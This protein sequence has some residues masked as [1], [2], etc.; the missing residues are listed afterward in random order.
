MTL[1]QLQQINVNL[2]PKDSSQ[3]TELYLNNSLK[4]GLQKLRN[5]IQCQ[6]LF[7][8][9]KTI[10]H[11]LHNLKKDQIL[12][13]AQEQMEYIRSLTATCANFRSS[14]HISERTGYKSQLSVL[15][16]GLLITYPK[17]QVQ[18]TPTLVC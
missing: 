9:I 8:L 17:G 5:R 10:H 7:P 3:I 15:I 6:S 16:L 12:H 1:D 4:K 13:Q 11:F 2:F 18:R 14:H